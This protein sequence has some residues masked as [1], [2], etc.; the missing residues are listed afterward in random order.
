MDESARL[1]IEECE[2][3]VQTAKKQYDFAG[4]NLNNGE[5]TKL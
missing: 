2:L 1:S 5:Q 3:A 4:K